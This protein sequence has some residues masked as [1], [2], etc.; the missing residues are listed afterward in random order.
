MAE[1]LSI[2]FGQPIPLFPLPNCVLLPHATIPLHIFEPRYRAMT[3]DAVDD[4]RLI[5][6]AAFE[7]DHW[8]DDYADRPSLR[9][10]VCVGFIVKD[11]HLS[12]GRF[13][14]LLQG[15]CRARIIE[16]IEP[17][18]DEDDPAMC[19]CDEHYRSALLAPTETGVPMEIDMTEHRQ[20]LEAQLNDPLLRKL[21]CVS[22]IHN[23]LNREIPTTVLV[24]LTIMSVCSDVNHRY[25]MLAQDDVF[26]RSDW[27]HDHLCRTR[28]TLEIAD[29][30]GAAQT[31]DGLGLN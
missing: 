28:K 2:D 12:D 29:R 22:A 15:I 21:A 14:I 7:D 18:E 17:V 1:T 11:E 5:A 27:L 4:R 9:E 20:Q 23:W 25:A 13:N 31:E 6:I 30:L 8:R 3:R 24:D 10:H 16:E 19:D 26:R